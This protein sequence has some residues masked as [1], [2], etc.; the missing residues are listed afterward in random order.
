[1]E[2]DLVLDLDLDLELVLVFV[3]TAFFSGFGFGFDL[4][5]A[6]GFFSQALL[7]PAGDVELA[8]LF[9]SKECQ[10]HPVRG[11]IVSGDSFYCEGQLVSSHTHVK[12]FGMK[13][14]K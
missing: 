2:L 9:G 7:S 11:V 6:F 12:E 14:Y 8:R 1:L 5:L 3:C 13:R 4:V 10:Q